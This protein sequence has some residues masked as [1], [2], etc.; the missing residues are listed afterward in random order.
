LETQLAQTGQGLIS[1]GQQYAGLQNQ[2][3]IALGQAQQAQSTAT[4]AA[5]TAF[6]GALGKLL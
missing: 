6:A 5:I 3:L 4:S 2:D 1:S